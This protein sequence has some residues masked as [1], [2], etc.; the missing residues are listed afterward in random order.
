MPV[1]REEVHIERVGVNGDVGADADAFTER[2]I[3]VP[4]MG[5][6]VVTAKRAHVVEEVRLHK[7]QVTETEQ[8][9]DSVRKE[10]VVIE[11]TDTQGKSVT[12][13]TRTTER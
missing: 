13:T 11:G 12:E 1:S 5:E 3:S 4:L 7:D 8:V 9:T 6:E 2:D 10:R